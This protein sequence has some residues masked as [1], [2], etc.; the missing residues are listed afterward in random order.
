MSPDASR[1]PQMSPDTFRCLQMSP[2]AAMCDH[3]QV[4]LSNELGSRVG[5]SRS[6]PSCVCSR[7]F[8]PSSKRTKWTLNPKLEAGRRRASAQARAEAE[9][10]QGRA[11][12]LDNVRERLSSTGH[13]Q[14][15]HTSCATTPLRSSKGIT[16]FPEP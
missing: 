2:D 13:P 6:G 12:K 14:W 10:Q 5:G 4:G 3:R 11:L 9:T 1:C 7:D 8:F 16:P 15:R